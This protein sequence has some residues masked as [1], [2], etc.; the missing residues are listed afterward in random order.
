M[1]ITRLGLSE[2][3]IARMSKADAIARMQEYWSKPPEDGAFT[4]PAGR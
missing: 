1:L 3:E 4:S 2:A